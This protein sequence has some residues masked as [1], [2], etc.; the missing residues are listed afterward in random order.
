MISA[1]FKVKYGVSK[2]HQLSYVWMIC[3]NVLEWKTATYFVLF[4][5][6]V[7]LYSL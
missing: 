2:T 3:L 4:C 1:C 5:G 6:V 7:V